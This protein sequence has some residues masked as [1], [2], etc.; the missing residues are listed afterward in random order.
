M[1]SMSQI[2]R[3]ALSGDAIAPEIETH[4]QSLLLSGHYSLDDLK[5]F[6]TL[7]V[8]LRDRCVALTS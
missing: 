2:V 1:P 4:V 3:Q 6:D 5:V 8:I 7:Q